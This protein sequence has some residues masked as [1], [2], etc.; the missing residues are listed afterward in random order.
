[1]SPKVTAEKAHELPTVVPLDEL[2][3]LLPPEP[4]SVDAT[5]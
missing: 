5:L 3:A 2:H 1:M 4:Y